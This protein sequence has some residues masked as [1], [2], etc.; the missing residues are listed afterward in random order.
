MKRLMFIG[1]VSLAIGLSSAS[2][3]LVNSDTEL[4]HNQ[5]SLLVSAGRILSLQDT[6]S[7]VSHYCKGK[8]IDA[9]L[10]Q[11]TDKWR[12]DLVFK[13]RGGE[14]LHL[15]VDARNGQ[16]VPGLPLPSECRQDETT[17]R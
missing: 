9:H 13:V 14:L 15:S 10:Y 16:P 17:A 4:H 7:I 2:A 1:T 12:Y 8:L 3:N 11:E 6:L 5:A